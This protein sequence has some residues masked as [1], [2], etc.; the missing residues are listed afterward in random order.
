M[1][2]LISIIVP[3]YN[4]EDY[5]ERCITSLIEQTYKNIEIIL[6]N[7]GSQD[8]SL[9]ICEKYKNIDSRI[10]IINKKNGGLSSARNAGIKIAKGKYFVFVDSDDYIDKTMIDFLHKDIQI[11]K[12]DISICGF[13]NVFENKIEKSIHCGEEFILNSEEVLTL[14]YSNYCVL[15][16]LSWNKIYKREIFDD[17]KFTE[18][19]VHEDDIIILD[20]INKCNIISFNLKPL[21]YYIQRKNSITGN[22]KINRL[23][24]LYALN[25]RD[26]YFKKINRK[27]LIDLNNYKKYYVVT[28][29]IK[30][31]N[32]VADKTQEI[33]NKIKECKI[34]KREYFNLIKHSKY[35]SI[36]KKLFILYSYYLERIYNLF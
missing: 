13:Y 3:I 34:N 11:K 9:K 10:R 26:Y 19:R 15:T 20:I 6:V 28:N 30:N 31:G 32:K 27:D 8:K 7:D 36:R 12:A 4:V 5:L 22:F 1:N 17:L 21:Y 14:L 35:I 2:E 16:S 24:G 33:K 18:G 25:Q 23:D 29:F